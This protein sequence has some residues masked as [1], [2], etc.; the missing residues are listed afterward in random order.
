[1]SQLLKTRD[2]NVKDKAERDF[3]EINFGKNSSSMRRVK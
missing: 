3:A 1:M 2:V